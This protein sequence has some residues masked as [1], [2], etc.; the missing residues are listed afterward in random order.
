MKYIL[1]AVALFALLASCSS[2]P[3]K[4]A[5][6]Q[7]SLVAV[8]PSDQP[9]GAG[10]ILRTDPAFDALVPRTRRGA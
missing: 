1:T 2:S 3:D 8:A 6:A 5:E 4:P 10:G 7:K 9:A